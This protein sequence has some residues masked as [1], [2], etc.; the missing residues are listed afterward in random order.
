MAFIEVKGVLRGNPNALDIA[1]VFSH[2]F[3]VFDLSMR[4]EFIENYVPIEFMWK[5]G[6]GYSRRILHVH[7]DVSSFNFGK[8]KIVGPFAIIAMSADDKS[9][10][11]IEHVVKQFGGFI[12][13]ERKAKDAQW[14][15]IVTN[16]G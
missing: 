4:P 9:Y 16:N 10:S 14:E 1:K 6:D 11:V 8:H 13:D 3:K 12:Q 2:H 5:N 7:T 15:E